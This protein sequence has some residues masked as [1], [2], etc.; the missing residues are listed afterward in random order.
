MSL[1][2]KSGDA[3]V[4]GGD[5][6][7]AAQGNRDGKAWGFNTATGIPMNKVTNSVAMHDPSLKYH[8]VRITNH[9]TGITQMALV[10]N[11]MGNPASPGDLTPELA[12]KLGVKLKEEKYHD[13]SLNQDFRWVKGDDAKNVTFEVVGEMKKKVYGDVATAQKVSEKLDTLKTVEAIEGLKDDAEFKDLV[14]LYPEYVDQVKAKGVDYKPE[15][16]TVAGTIKG[17]HG[18]Q[19]GGSH[20]EDAERI[21]KGAKQ[22]I[23]GATDEDERKKRS[24]QV[25]DMVSGIMQDEPLL[26]LLLILAMAMSGASGADIDKMLGMFSQ[27][28]GGRPYGSGGGYEDYERQYRSGGGKWEYKSQGKI[29][30]VSS[31]PAYQ[32]LKFPEYKEGQ[33]GADYLASV[34]EHFASLNLREGGGNSGIFPEWVREPMGR[35]NSNDPYC[36]YAI[37]K[38][39]EGTGLFNYTGSAKNFMDQ[40]AATGSFRPGLQGVRRGDIIV[41]DRG[42]WKGHVGMVVA[43]DG[44]KITTVEANKHDTGGLAIEKQT[45]T[46]AQLQG[47]NVMGYVDIRDRAQKLGKDLTAM[48]TKWNNGKVEITAPTQQPGYDKEGDPALAPINPTVGQSG[49]G[50]GQVT[51]VI[52]RGHGA[53]QPGL[54]TGAVSPDKALNEIQAMDKYES[55]LKEKFEAK[56]YKVVLTSPT[57]GASQYHNADASRAARTAIANSAIGDGKGIY[58]SL[59]SN[60]TG[61]GGWQTSH[62]GSELYYAGHV[63]GS[64]ELA[65]MVKNGISANKSTNYGRGSEKNGGA[66]LIQFQT[67][68]HPSILL[69]A[70]YLDNKSDKAALADGSL[71]A[72]QSDKIVNA[73][74]QFVNKKWGKELQV[75][76]DAAAKAA[77]EKAAADAAKKE[78]AAKPAA[79]ARPSMVDPATEANMAREA[80]ERAAK[81][82]AAP[83]AKPEASAAPAKLRNVITLG[84]EQMALIGGE[85]RSQN[86]AWKDADKLDVSKHG[87]LMLDIGAE[88]VRNRDAGIQNYNKLAEVIEKSQKANPNLG[89]VLIKPETA[90]ST[91]PEAVQIIR[92][93]YD[94]LQEKYG[95]AVFDPEGKNIPK[96]EDGFHYTAAGANIVFA[97]AKE[98]ALNLPTR[99]AEV[100]LAKPVASTGDK[101]LDDALKVANE[102]AASDEAKRKAREEAAKLA[103]TKASEEEAKK[104]AGKVSQTDEQKEKEKSDVAAAHAAVVK[105][106]TEGKLDSLSKVSEKKEGEA[107]SKTEDAATATKALASAGVTSKD[108]SAESEA[109]RKVAPTANT[110][111]Q[112]G[113]QLA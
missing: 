30:G 96:S 58:I 78:A 40:G 79:P 14:E 11:V 41:F 95:I 42:G 90:G 33:D 76:K 107:G 39:T 18:K 2:I 21:A 24:G 36:A 7:A 22:Y 51:V 27:A 67:A 1:I 87:V 91:N 26:A 19:T 17:K 48:Y 85:Q 31:N 70:G 25:N 61:K 81:E 10:T 64:E 101:A 73:V 49:N 92:D 63:A 93:R 74:D 6:G 100:T 82:K 52:D 28:M 88:T 103:E 89:I 75:E 104:D 9:D 5:F 72:S 4:Y 47:R 106:K 23:N 35:T 111:T 69:E 56:G 57:I 20:E 37:G 50:A 38:F 113:A 66:G 54:D 98:E 110:P 84:G 86:L 55:A 29:G 108:V 59:H 83:P 34:A 71:A 12:D 77:A 32:G 45:Y 53:R 62:S 60:D 109:E 43:V 80:A 102:L 8:V 3:T 65:G 13:A 94:Q 16:K 15:A 97:Y 112:P 68:K 105:L 46:V 99:K 44:D